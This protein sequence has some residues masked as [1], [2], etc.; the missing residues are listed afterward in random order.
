MNKVSLKRLFSVQKNKFKHHPCIQH[1]LVSVSTNF[2]AKQIIMNFRAKFAQKGYLWS[3]PGQ[4]ITT[5]EFTIFEVVYAPCFI[6][7]KEFWC[8][9]SN[10]PQKSTFTQKQTNWTS[11]SKFNIVDLVQMANF[12][13]KRQF[14][15][16]LWPDLPKKDRKVLFIVNNSHNLKIFHFLQNSLH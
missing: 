6:L 10:F 1:I 15:F 12:I 8:F 4:M 3:K 14:W 11:P 13:L 5:I 7:E 9:L 16:F 2:H